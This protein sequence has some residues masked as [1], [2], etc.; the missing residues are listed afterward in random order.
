MTAVCLAGHLHQLHDAVLVR[1]EECWVA[2]S[3]SHCASRYNLC[4]V[5]GFVSVGRRRL[6]LATVGKSWQQLQVSEIILV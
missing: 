6:V 4:V 1:D 5:L 3:P 2:V